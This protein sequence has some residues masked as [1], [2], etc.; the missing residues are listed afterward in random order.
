MNCRYKFIVVLKR[1]F[2]DYNQTIKT[3][4][5]QIILKFLFIDILIIVINQ[6]S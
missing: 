2:Y 1:D 6:E 4:T 3:L 5:Y